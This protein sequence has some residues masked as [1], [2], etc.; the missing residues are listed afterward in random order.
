MLGQDSRGRWVVEDEDGTRGG[1]FVDRAQALRYIRAEIGDLPCAL[2]N[3]RGVLDLDMA[4]PTASQ[5]ADAADEREALAL[6][7]ER[8]LI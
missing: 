4:S 5:S 1:W 3:V 7:V 2:V 6:C 8:D